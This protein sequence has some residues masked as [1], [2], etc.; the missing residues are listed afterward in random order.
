MANSNSLSPFLRFLQKYGVFGSEETKD[1]AILLKK[2]ITSDI[3]KHGKS[4][5]NKAVVLCLSDFLAM[6]PPEDCY[7]M[8]DRIFKAWR[9]NRQE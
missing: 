2:M 1:Y 7:S 9:K 8:A 6:Q 4:D 5:V 3:R